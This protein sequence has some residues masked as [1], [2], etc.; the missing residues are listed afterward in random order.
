MTR[1]AA[2]VLAL[3]TAMPAL[4]ADWRTYVNARFGTT[5]DYPAD[6]FAAEPE[7]DDG[8]GRR[9]VSADGRASLTVYAGFNVDHRSLRALARAAL[10][11][12]ADERVTYEAAGRRWFVLSGFRGTDVFY[13]K[14]ILSPDGAVAHTLELTYPATEKR[15]YD[16]LTARIA[17]SMSAGG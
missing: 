16:P 1:L 3:L 17:N 14:L 15:V 12:A 10:K 9:F 5:L 2:L 13:R 7:A 6:V 8:D 4:A 11:D